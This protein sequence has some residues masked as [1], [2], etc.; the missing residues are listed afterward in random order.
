MSASVRYE[1]LLPLALVIVVGVLFLVMPDPYSPCWGKT[2]VIQEGQSIASIAREHEVR[3][4]LVH[5]CNAGVYG[6]GMI[7]PGAHIRVQDGLISK[8]LTTVLFGLLI[9][10]V[11]AWTARTGAN[12][13][14]VIIARAA[15]GFVVAIWF[16]FGSTWIPWCIGTDVEGVQSLTKMQRVC[17]FGHSPGEMARSANPIW[18]ISF[19]ATLVA[20]AAS[21]KVDRWHDSFTARGATGL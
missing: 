20:A 13:N 14:W 11:L 17:T 15:F 1:L 19:W 9:M 21:L 3:P 18:F 2:V 16:I 8:S 10:T 5:V 7:R 12:K 4:L 6:H